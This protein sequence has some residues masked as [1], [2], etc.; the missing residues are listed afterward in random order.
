MQESFYI[1]SDASLVIFVQISGAGTLGYTKSRC[2]NACLPKIRDAGTS[3]LCVPDHSKH[4][5]LTKK[6]RLAKKQTEVIVAVGLFLQTGK[7]KLL[8]HH[9][10]SGLVSVPGDFNRGCENQ[11]AK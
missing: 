8:K 1:N 2:R 10:G 6:H 9:L 4:C 5:T 11:Y 7:K 3:F